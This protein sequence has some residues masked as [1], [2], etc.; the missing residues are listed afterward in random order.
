MYHISL[1]ISLSPLA[2]YTRAI[3]TQP[4][5]TLYFHLWILCSSH[6]YSPFL[7]LAKLFHVLVLLNV[8]TSLHEMS[9]FPTIL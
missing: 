1:R 8:S 7:D 2:K 9:I 6:I 3:M 4:L 5:L